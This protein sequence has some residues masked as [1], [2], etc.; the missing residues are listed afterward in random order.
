MAVANRVWTTGHVVIEKPI[1]DAFGI[2]PGWLTTQRI[3]NGHVEVHFHPP[4]HEE[5][6]PG[7][8]PPSESEQRSDED[9]R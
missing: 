4:E 3:V 1:R 6:L 8:L 7:E 9:P 2:D 5:V